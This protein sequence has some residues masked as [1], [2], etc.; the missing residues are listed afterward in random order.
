MNS[1]IGELIDRLITTSQ[2]C[3]HAQDK[4][5]DENLSDEEVVKY[6]RLAQMTNIERSKLVKEIDSF[7]GQA[8]EIDSIKSYER[9]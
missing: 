8:K 4:I 9:K 1:T 5:M 7:F 2:K 6:A 3:W